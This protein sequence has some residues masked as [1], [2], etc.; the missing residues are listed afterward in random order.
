MY[1]VM[2]FFS[3]I[4]SAFTSFAFAYRYVHVT[5]F[6]YYFPKFI[7]PFICRRQR[8]FGE[9]SIWCIYSIFWRFLD[10]FSSFSFHSVSVGYCNAPQTY[11]HRLSLINRT[12]LLPTNSLVGSKWKLWFWKNYSANGTEKLCTFDECTVTAVAA[13]SA[14][15]INTLIDNS[16]WPLSWHL[17]L[18]K[19]TA[20]T[21]LCSQACICVFL[22]PT[23]CA[24]A[25]IY[26]CSQCNH[27]IQTH[28]LFLLELKIRFYITFFP[29]AS[30]MC[31]RRLMCL[32]IDDRSAHLFMSFNC[33]H[34]IT[35]HR[36]ILCRIVYPSNTENLNRNV[37]IQFYF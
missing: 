29:L 7:L 17:I 27:S 35:I 12:A 33:T 11:H 28:L 5:R 10:C 3:S 16:V 22:S 14:C 34:C 36:H 6:I 23:W 15:N 32:S 37:S 2:V 1:F 18:Y 19:R 9:I 8:L 31:M 4:G 13:S 21:K 26:C 24:W 30:S 25:N 20:C